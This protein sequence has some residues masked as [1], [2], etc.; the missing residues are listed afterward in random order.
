M[1]NEVLLVSKETLNDMKQHYTTYLKPSTPPGGLFAAKK[2]AVNITAY[3][4][5]KVLFQGAG[6]DREAAVWQKKQQLFQ[7]RINPLLL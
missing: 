4:S 7:L 6:S 2:G 1:A 3:N 5:G